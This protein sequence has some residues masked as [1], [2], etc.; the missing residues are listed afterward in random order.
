ME[1]RQLEYVVALAEEGQFTRAADLVR[2]SQ[3]GLSAAIRG[4]ESELGCRLFERT[5]RKVELT[6]AGQ[7]LLPF[8]RSILAQ[9]AAARDAIERSAETFTSLY[10]WDGKDSLEEI[11]CTAVFRKNAYVEEEHKI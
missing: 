8:A 7:A 1:L 5:T 6:Q 2:I 3:S 4:L 11:G 10:G 9:A